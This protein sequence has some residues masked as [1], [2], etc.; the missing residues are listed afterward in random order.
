MSLAAALPRPSADVCGRLRAER[1]EA[2]PAVLAVVGGIDAG[3]AEVV[4]RHLASA[5]SRR[6]VVIDLSGV[7]FV[8]SRGVGV[9]AGA[10]CRIQANGGRVALVAPDASLAQALV[11]AG[12]S[13][14]VPLCGSAAEA[15]RRV[16]EDAHPAP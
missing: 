3:T 6:R 12:F 9:L 5:Y 13:R 15:E 8:D 10:V 14:L 7:S 16:S 2:R 4:R 11:T 1:A